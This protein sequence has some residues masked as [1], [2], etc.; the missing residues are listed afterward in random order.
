MVPMRGHARPACS[1]TCPRPGSRGV[2]VRFQA[3]HMFMK[4]LHTLTRTIAI[5]FAKYTFTLKPRWIAI[6]DHKERKSALKSAARRITQ[7]NAE[8]LSINH[9][10]L[11]INH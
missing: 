5:K 11:T 8:S 2:G 4:R 10:P 9:Q 6:E 1:F 7:N 3:K